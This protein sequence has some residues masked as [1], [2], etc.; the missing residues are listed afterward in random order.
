M[1]AVMN[2][3][4]STSSATTAFSWGSQ[5]TGQGLCRIPSRS[6]TVIP[7][8]HVPSDSTS[9]RVVAHVAIEGSTAIEYA[10]PHFERGYGLHSIALRYFNAA[11][12]DPDGE[13]GEDH[14]PE[15]H[16]IPRALDAAM[17]RDSFR[18]FG[19][20]YPTPDGTCLRDY[21]HVNDL[22]SAHALAVDARRAGAPS[23]AYTLG[24]GRPTSVRDVLAS[25]VRVTGTRGPGVLTAGRGGDPAALLAS[26]DRARRE[27]GR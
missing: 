1:N 25:V 9:T 2:A 10:L 12:A 5:P 3:G 21:V 6:V 7:R 24:N 14:H 18:V 8:V 20:D 17:G 16:V 22:A 23:N 27:R 19:D 13:L 4:A 15:I 11:G 26:S